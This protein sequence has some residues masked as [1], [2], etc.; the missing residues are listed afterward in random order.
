MAQDIATLSINVDSTGV[1]K[2]TSDLKDFTGSA[3]ATEAATN[4]LTS[5]VAALGIAL[6]AAT[7]VMATKE[8]A[9]L[10]A[11]YETLG[12]V[13]EVMGNNAGYTS[14]QMA[15]LQKELQATGIS[16]LK[17]REAINMLSA[18]QVDLSKAGALARIAQDAAVIANTNSS[19]AF[20]R[21]TNSI[22]TGMVIQAHHLGIMV[23][24]EA[25]YK[26]MKDQLG[27]HNRELT[28]AEKT[29]ARFNGVLEEGA[30]R[31]GVYAAAMGTTGKQIN[32]MDRYI[33]DLEVKFGNMFG[34]ALSAAVE[35]FTNGLKDAQATLD[36]M[37]AD[38]SMGLFQQNL[39]DG[40]TSTISTIKTA[41]AFLY[42]HKDAILM[43]GGAWLSVSAGVKTF[44]IVKQVQAWTSAQTALA[45]QIIFAQKAKEVEVVLNA[46]VASGTM[47]LSG[48]TREQMRND[49][50][51]TA[52]IEAKAAAQNKATA[53]QALM[54]SGAATA[55]TAFTSLAGGIGLVM[56]AIAL[57]TIA[58]QTFKDTTMETA[59]TAS[60]SMDDYM[61]KLKEQIKAQNDYWNKRGA[62]MSHEDAL[63]SSVDAVD[64]NETF[65]AS[66]KAYGELQ[67]RL[68][69]IRPAME[70]YLKLKA[71]VAEGNGL[72]E[73]EYKS[74]G[75]L[76]AEARAYD[77]TTKAIN[78]N[79]TKRREAVELALQARGGKEGI[80]QARIADGEAARKK[81]A[82][83][84]SKG[85][86]TADH[87]IY[88]REVDAIKTYIAGLREASTLASK[89]QSDVDKLWAEHDAK[90]NSWQKDTQG[91]NPKLTKGQAL[92]LELQDKEARAKA[93]LA[94]KQRL[95]DAIKQVDADTQADLRKGEADTWAA[96]EAAWAKAFDDLNK[97]RRATGNLTE[98]SDKDRQDFL[99]GE[100]GKALPSEINRLRT[101]LQDLER[102]KGR[103]LTF[104]EQLAAL[105]G[106]ADK[107]GSTTLAVAKLEKELL[108]S[109]LH[110]QDFWGGFRTGMEDIG[111]SMSDVFSR[112]KEMATDF[113]NK[114]IDALTRFATT[115]RFEMKSFLA[116]LATDI[117]RFYMQ[118]AVAN[119]I[120]AFAGSFNSGSGTG[121]YEGGYASM[122]NFNLGGAHAYGGDVYGGRPV[123]VGENGPEVYTP[124]TD[125]TII[126][127]HQL[128]AQTVDASQ[129]HMHF[130]EGGVEK[131][132][133]Q[134]TQKSRAMERLL[135]PMI[136]SV[137]AEERR[138]TGIMNPVFG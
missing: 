72:T 62:G 39:K 42:E 11:R 10:T 45:A 66:D 105:D 61:A 65:A 46:R 136:R 28:D 53:A 13:M 111:N 31:A 27:I 115:G 63:K 116:D 95:A 3:K 64:K 86:V 125:G 79:L 49:M 78:A 122:Y 130:Y 87:N 99:Q 51:A 18:A 1:R 29:Q 82:E 96:K 8:A 43:I 52:A 6:S 127:N 48:V 119:L 90:V 57:A 88:Q 131:Q 58:Y 107:I 20:Q 80:E 132:S 4:Q 38:G 81:A 21:L 59:K 126:P 89:A 32:S 133:G 5:A 124:P 14:G 114:G 19:D 109:K 15:T 75:M 135:V 120:G 85:K 25:S 113:S 134:P 24:Y 108:K 50:L 71:K 102:V 98:F 68:E 30:K 35:G 121:L 128:G 97:R 22:Q 91:K 100:R 9:L 55:T 137:L 7:V 84:G 40:V 117:A 129:I 103:A 104:D 70:Q 56:G 2:G 92:D 69:K 54:S 12:V 138:A 44:E 110:D 37:S 106:V 17:S 94:I 118:K 123:L 83:E 36:K 101:A 34:P 74:M 47:I 73:T 41:T 67:V 76:A 16:A 33:Q 93:E 26:R 60:K 77:E 23:S 112:G